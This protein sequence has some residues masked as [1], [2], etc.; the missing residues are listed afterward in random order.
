MLSTVFFPE[1]LEAFQAEHPEIPVVLEEYGSVRACSLVQD[2]TLDFALVN[3]EQYNID[4][5]NNIILADDQIVFCVSK[6]HPL[7]QKESV[8]TQEVQR[9]S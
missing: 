9:K 5:F 2:D 4:K 3:M 8:T 1:L 7:A 6:D